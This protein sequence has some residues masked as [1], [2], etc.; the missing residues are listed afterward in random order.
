MSRSQIFLAVDDLSQNQ[1]HNLQ[2]RAGGYRGD[3]RG[4]WGTERRV[5]IVCPDCRGPSQVPLKD[6]IDPVTS[7]SKDSISRLFDPGPL[8][9]SACSFAA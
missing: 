6:Y 1:S 3:V 9:S 2:L 8:V 5:A 7:A 4:R